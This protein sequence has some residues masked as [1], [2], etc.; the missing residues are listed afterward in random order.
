MITRKEVEFNKDEI[1]T[2]SKFVNIVWEL[3]VKT[4][5]SENS[6]TNYFLDCSEDEI[7]EGKHDLEIIEG[8]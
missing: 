2:I 8:Y 5:I 7:N 6:I 4:G 3:S 1:A